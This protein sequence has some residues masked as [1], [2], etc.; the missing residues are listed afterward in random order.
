MTVDDDDDGFNDDNN[1]DDD[2]N[3]FNGDDDDDNAN[4]RAH[5]IIVMNEGKIAE[6]DTPQQLLALE[7]GIYSSLWSQHEK[8]H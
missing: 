3:D 4:P 1:N 8:S 2:F 5:R 7:G 6:F